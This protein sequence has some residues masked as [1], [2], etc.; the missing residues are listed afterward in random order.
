[1][2][3]VKYD[4]YRGPNIGIYTSVNDNFVFIPNGFTMTKAEALARHLG[5][6]YRNIS[7]G[8]TRV[9]GALMIV[10][11]HGLLLPQTAYPDEIEF[12]EKN[13]GLNV[14]ILETRHNALGNMMS[15][16]DR[17]AIVSPLIEKENLKKIEQTLGVE[18]IQRRVAGYNQVG[19]MVRANSEGGIVHPETD[20]EDIKTFSNVLG[21]NLEPATINGGVPFV[22][23]GTLVNNKTIVVGSFTTGP[24][25]MMLTRAFVNQRPSGDH[26]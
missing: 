22:A 3:I 1:M 17:G 8:N 20:E 23:S 25:I 11:N 6:E 4:V 19:A 26:R 5:V 18:V 10:N 7:V 24:E 14:E 16:N 9:I 2:D 13:T 12:L 21:V 15:V